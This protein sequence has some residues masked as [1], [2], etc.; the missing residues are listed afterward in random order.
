MLVLLAVAISFSVSSPPT[1]VTA[2]ARGTTR[3]SGSGRGP[4]AGGEPVTE[5]LPD[6]R[7]LQPHQL[8]G[9]RCVL[10]NRYLGAMARRLGPPLLDRWGYRYQLYACRPHCPLRRYPES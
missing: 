5:P 10:C 6:L 2:S 3:R 8:M 9:I 1:L 7:R 4:V